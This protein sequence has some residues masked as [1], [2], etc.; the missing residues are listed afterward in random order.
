MPASGLTDAASAER[1][2]GRF[3]QALH[4]FEL[5]TKHAVA[6]THRARQ[7]SSTGAIRPRSRLRVTLVTFSGTSVFIGRWTP[8][9][10][11]RDDLPEMFARELAALAF[12]TDLEA[13]GLQQGRPQRRL[14]ARCPRVP[15]TTS[16]SP[17][18]AV[19]FAADATTESL[20]LTV[21]RSRSHFEGLSRVRELSSTAKR[22]FTPSWLWK[23]SERCS[24]KPSAPL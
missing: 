9:G 2:R 19:W 13:G 21:C 22:S 5:C 1:P 14:L 17:A 15:A 23:P 3:H 11:G 6:R 8:S 12:P 20:R 18:S 7:I 4:G 16:S 10:G 24:T